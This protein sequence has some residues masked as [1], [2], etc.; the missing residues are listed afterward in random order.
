MSVSTTCHDPAV[1]TL[2]RLCSAALGSDRVRWD[3]GP[4]RDHGMQAFMQAEGAALPHIPDLVLEGF[5]GPGTFT[6]VEVKTFDPAGPTH[7]AQHHTDRDRG[8]AHARISATARSHDYHLPN[9]PLPRRMRLV[10][11]TVST[12]GA[13][14]PA[15]LAFIA[16]LGR[17]TSRYVPASLHTEV[18]WAAPAWRPLSACP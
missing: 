6:L 13:I 18:T 15:G 14:G 3:G 10:V 7:I 1:S 2:G 11:V 5:D 9:I 12:S 17:R 8:A 4:G 16:E